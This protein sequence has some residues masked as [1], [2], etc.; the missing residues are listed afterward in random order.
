MDSGRIAGFSGA[1]LAVLVSMS[2]CASPSSNSTTVDSVA[3][4]SACGV[5]LTW[6]WD[7]SAGAATRTEALADISAYLRSRE[8]DLVSANARPGQ[9]DGLDDPLKVRIAIRNLEEL[10]RELQLV[11]M[12]A[13]EGDDLLVEADVK[14]GGVVASALIIAMPAGG[15]RLDTLVAPG[16]GIDDAMCAD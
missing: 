12:S 10:S 7:G 14:Q 13:R 11:E 2:A 4:P 16:A 15:Y 8:S 9:G 5:T 6:D 1:M 3:A